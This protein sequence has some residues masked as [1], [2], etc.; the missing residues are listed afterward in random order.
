MNV[1]HR[2]FNVQRPINEENLSIELTTHCN[3]ACGHCFARTGIA[4][5]AD[6]P[7]HLVKEMVTEGY[8]AGYRH[9]HLT[10]GEPLLWDGLFDVL[11]HVDDV[12]YHTVF[13]N[14]NG[15]LLTAAISGRLAEF[16]GLSI[17]ISLEAT[18]DLHDRMRG[19]GAWQ[20]AASGIET[21]LKAGIETFIFT[22]AFK[23]SLSRLPRFTAE[24][25]ER[26]PETMGIVLIQLIRVAHSD[27]DL[28]AE[29]LD[30]DDFLKM[31]RAVSLLNCYGLKID[32]LYSPLAHVTAKRLNMPWIPRSRPRHRKGRLMIRANGDM[33]FSH[34]AGDR[35]ATYRPGMI[36]RVLSSDAYG[37][38]T[39][40]DETTCPSCGF[41]E[42]CRENGMVRP[43]GRDMG[44]HAETP[45]C[46][47]VLERAA[48]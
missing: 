16:D 42:L 1:Q 37:K 23:S 21:A 36:Y 26:F 13:L 11:D 27:F 47:R 25:Y 29:L 3:S 46:I 4:G 8:A 17:S 40:P 24:M 41:A 15:T 28:S 12:G 38:F 14:T 10:G 45:Y 19:A 7:V 9:L 35:T 48:Q 20:S 22:T 43:T 34:S 6:L 18:E 44:P 2:T 5:P 32:V 30:P 39:A 33:T 31:V